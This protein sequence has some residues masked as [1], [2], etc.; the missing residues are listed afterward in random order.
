RP[1]PGP[2]PRAIIRFLTQQRRPPQPHGWAPPAPVPAE[3]PRI[4]KRTPPMLPPPS[5]IPDP[6]SRIP[7][8]ASRSP[9]SR[10]R[11]RPGRLERPRRRAGEWVGKRPKEQGTGGPAF[12]I[13]LELELELELGCPLGD[14]NRVPPGRSKSEFR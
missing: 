3:S 1:A 11:L 10:A 14:R 2:C 9:C 4:T 12:P 5:R 7:H 13:E 8:P 6:A